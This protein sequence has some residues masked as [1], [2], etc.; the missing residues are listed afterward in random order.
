MKIVACKELRLCTSEMLAFGE[1]GS[2]Q[3]AKDRSEFSS[4]LSF[5]DPLGCKIRQERNAEILSS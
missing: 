1:A 5:A 3:I 2:V 4:I